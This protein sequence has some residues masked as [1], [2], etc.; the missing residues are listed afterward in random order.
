MKVILAVVDYDAHVVGLLKN[1]QDEVVYINNW[2]RKR[3]SGQHK[4]HKFKVYN[5]EPGH[6]DP[7]PL[8][9]IVYPVEYHDFWGKVSV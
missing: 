8:G 5:F 3:E 1:T 7:M 6:M 2:L 4:P 9:T